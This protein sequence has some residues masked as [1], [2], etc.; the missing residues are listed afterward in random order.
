MDEGQGSCNPNPSKPVASSITH[1]GALAFLGVLL[2]ALPAHAQDAG[3]AAEHAQAACAPFSKATS[4]GRIEHDAVD[5]ASGLSASWRHEGL[6]WTHNDSG[7]QPRLFL[8]Q[9]DGTTA[10]VVELGAKTKAKDWEDVAVG[11]CEKGSKH[12]CVYVADIG[13]NNEKR[14]EVVIY[15]FRE[16]EL[17]DE[18]PAT[19]TVDE[20]DALWFRYPGGPRN[21]ETVMV[22][23]ETAQIYVVEKTAQ[24]APGIYRIPRQT[25]D[26]KHPV[27]AVE[28]GQL[29]FDGASGFGRLVTAGD[30][31]PDGDEFT[32]RTY[33]AA[34]TFCAT[35]DDFESSVDADPVISSV[36]F[37]VQ[38]EAL[39]YGR[40]G[41]SIWLTSERR[42][43]P[44]YRVERK[45]VSPHTKKPDKNKK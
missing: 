2:G 6:L 9:A 27:L 43:A 41:R 1:I 8:M 29:R 26:R 44:I 39:G 28:L 31:S 16:P 12:A 37:M 36:P 20:V 10:A 38:A 25:S 18:R 40:D 42:P 32:V 19:I 30:I 15:R 22:H 14:K 45:T 7:G 11:P 3:D 4:T 35:T 33:I 13:D 34:Y 21:A 23:P 24:R 17:P 5:E